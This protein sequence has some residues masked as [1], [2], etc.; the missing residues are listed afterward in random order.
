MASVKA[1]VL[2]SWR[3][4][5]RILKSEGGHVGGGERRNMEKGVDGEGEEEGQL[6]KKRERADVYQ[7]LLGD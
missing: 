2:E 4:Y 3:A 6:E 5:C 7:S 1:S